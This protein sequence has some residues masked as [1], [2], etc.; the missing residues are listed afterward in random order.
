MK[1]LTYLRSAIATAFSANAFAD[2]SVSGSA[3]LG[4]VNDATGDNNLV[5]SAALSFGM[6]TTTSGGLG[7]S[8]TMGLSVSPTAENGNTG[9]GGQTLTFTTGGS[10]VKVGDIEIA[11]TPGSVG[12]VAGANTVERSALSHSVG[13]GFRDD[14][15]Q[16]VMLTTGVG[17][18]T[19][20]G[21][22]SGVVGGA[23]TTGAQVAGGTKAAADAAT[24][25]KAA[26]DAANVVEA[27]ETVKTASDVANAANTVSTAGSTGSALMSGVGALAAPVAIGLGVAFL[28]NKLF[29]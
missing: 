28:L 22:G 27:A 8:A 10:T 23:T 13:G 18:A 16:G 20:A 1:K 24:T 19:G 17:G 11:D 4:Y 7:I 6:S 14:A 29:D 2:I 15:G 21:A 12:G 3:G 5:N 25:V 26:Q 9:T